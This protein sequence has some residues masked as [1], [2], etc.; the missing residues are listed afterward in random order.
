M[1]GTPQHNTGANALT[2]TLARMMRGI[3]N[4]ASKTQIDFGIINPD[5]SLTTNSF[6]VPIPPNGYSVCRS[7][8]YDPSVPLT[9]TYV[10][11]EH[12]HPDASPP[13]VHWHDVK[14]PRKMYWVRPG[15]KVLVAIVQNEFIVV[16]IVYDASWLGNQEPPWE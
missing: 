3:A 1:E 10:D 7:L 9:Q 12:E 2:N 15:Q 4:A 11:G 16:D 5:Y 8:L 14:L 13:G 6:P